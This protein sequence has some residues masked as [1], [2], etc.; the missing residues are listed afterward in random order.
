M[1]LLNSLAIAI[2]MYSKIPVPNV[3]WN[4]K[5]MKYA[6]CF[7]PVVGAVIGIIQF[8]IGGFL[9]MYTDCGSLFF[10]VVMALIPVVITGGI[11][12]DGYADTTDALSSYGEKEKKLEILKDP[13]TGAFAVI[14]LCVYFLADAALWS[15]VTAEML[16]VHVC[17]FQTFERNLG[18][19]LSGG[20]EQRAFKDI[21]GWG[22]ASQSKDCTYILAVRLRG[23]DDFPVMAAGGGCPADSSGCVHLLLQDEHEAVRGNNRRPCGI[24]PAGV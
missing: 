22:A 10:A 21:S 17:D 9:L 6:M 14:G 20:K 11:H 8:L 15:E 19:Q 5:N 3:E 7:F 23:A 24:F 18:C 1:Y 16:P 13:H 4:E 12:L 2:S